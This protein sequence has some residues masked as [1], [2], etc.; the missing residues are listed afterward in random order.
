LLYLLKLNPPR[1]LIAGFAVII[2]FG[3][4]FLSM[5]FATVDGKGLP[6][7]DAFF[8]ATS[9]VCVTGLAV[10]DTGTTFTFWGQLVIMLLIQIGGMGFMTFGTFF[11]VLL[12]KRIYFKERL[13]LQEALSQYSTEG[14][15]RLVR[16][17]AAVT[18]LIQFT[19]AIFL[20]ARFARDMELP[21]AAFF[22]LFHSV[23]AFNN[24][25]FDLFGNFASLTGYAAD[26]FV[27]A[28]IAGL[29]IIGGLGFT[30]TLD[31]FNQRKFSA[32]SLNSKITLTATATL[33]IAGALFILLL[34][35][36]NPATLGPL[37]SFARIQAA[38]F[39]SATARTAGFNTIDTASLLNP[40][41]LVVM[42]LMFI[43]ASS[44]S[45]GGGI[46]VTTLSILLLTVR[47][48]ATGQENP[49]A[50]SR[51]IGSQIVGKAIAIFF[52]SLA[53]VLTSAF[54]LTLFEEAEFL[55]CLFEAV[56]A[57]ATVGLSMGITPDL[58]LPGKIVVIVTM[59][60]GRLGPLTIAMALTVRGSKS[61]IRYPEEKL[62]LG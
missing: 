1:L 50:Y 16:Y 26:F 54:L 61:Q 53:L 27:N 11:A 7:I 31:I 59:F 49:I 36:V 58:S 18:F 60:F 28:V 14:I 5:P 20:T 3:A 30:V 13:I 46:K 45:T 47:S 48:I 25:G 15:I 29:L 41:I 17:I 6:L 43:G 55:P 39:Q 51:R 42:I 34:E 33:L 32:L 35:R 4:L 44:G 22:G 37:D 2:L 10:V 9:A 8:T 62:L 19:G 12:G 21:Q 24:A 40:S 56:S 38:F 52:A 23:S 57:F